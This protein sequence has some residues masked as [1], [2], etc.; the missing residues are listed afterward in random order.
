MEGC[1]DEMS[2][3]VE[4]TFVVIQACDF[5]LIMNVIQQQALFKLEL[6]E[7]MLVDPLQADLIPVFFILNELCDGQ[8]HSLQILFLYE[9]QL[10]L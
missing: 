1:K 10:V 2:W 3:V 7:V 8:L 6:H 5:T 4:C 9:L